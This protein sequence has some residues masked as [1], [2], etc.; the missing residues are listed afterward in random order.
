MV[1]HIAADVVVLIH[2]FFVLFVVLG[3]FLVL[4][5]PWLAWLHLPAVIW[6]A[7][8]ELFGLICPLTPLEQAL[9]QSA[10][11]TPYR[12]S[13]IAHYILQLLYPAGLT[14]SIQLVLG[15]VVLLVNGAIYGL[16]LYRRAKRARA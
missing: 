3:G 9:R 14:R 6:G 15:A 8:L 11:E 13:F 2:F 5:W 10:G 12:G 4:R 16:L 1:E 7:V